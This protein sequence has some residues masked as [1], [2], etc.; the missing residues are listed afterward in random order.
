MW[1]LFYFRLNEVNKMSR[2]TEYR[3]C[4]LTRTNGTSTYTTVT[5]LPVKYAIVGKNVELQESDSGWSPIWTVQATS[6]FTK[7]ASEFQTYEQMVRGHRQATGDSTK[8]SNIDGSLGS[9]FGK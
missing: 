8:R 5:F 2:K 3:Q 1:G 9:K 4:T 7:E 6:N